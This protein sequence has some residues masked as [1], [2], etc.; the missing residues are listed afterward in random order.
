MRGWE[1]TLRGKI[2]QIYAYGIKDRW[3]EMFVIRECPLKRFCIPAI[4]QNL[5]RSIFSLF[6]WKYLNRLTDNIK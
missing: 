6:T 3:I 4:N 2:I 1:N 5:V